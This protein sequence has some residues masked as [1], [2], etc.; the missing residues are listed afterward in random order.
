MNRREW[1]GAGTL[2]TISPWFIPPEK[3]RL[4]PDVII[5]RPKTWYIPRGLYQ[6]KV[7]THVF[8][9]RPKPCVFGCDKGKVIVPF[10]RVS[11]RS[12][13]LSSYDPEPADPNI[14]VENA[15]RNHAVIENIEASAE[16][17][18]KTINRN[19]VAVN[20]FLDTSDGHRVTELGIVTS[21]YN[22]LLTPAVA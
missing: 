3:Y 15:I 21:P 19:C 6:I 14:T 2:L 17:S 18:Y 12:V 4:T 10:F 1:F 22:D 9:G 8:V 11:P 5:S 7:H 13:V 20:L 16:C